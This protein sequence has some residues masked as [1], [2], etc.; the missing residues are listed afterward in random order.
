MGRSVQFGDVVYQKLATDLRIKIIQ[1]NSYHSIHVR[2]IIE[3]AV[4]GFGSLVHFLTINARLHAR[5]SSINYQSDWEETWPPGLFCPPPKQRRLALLVGFGRSTSFFPV[6]FTSTY[7]QVIFSC[8]SANIVFKFKT[9]MK[10][11]SLK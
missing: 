9:T 1:W 3:L 4:V 2:L 8:I 11:F 10:L 7:L 5:P 6:E